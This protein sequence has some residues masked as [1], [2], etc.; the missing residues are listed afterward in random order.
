MSR[1]NGLEKPFDDD[2]GGHS[3]RLGV[4]VGDDPMP[5]DRRG[6]RGHVIAGHARAAIQDGWY[7]TGD[8]AKYDDDGFITI[9]D[10]LARFSKIG[11]EMV[12]HQKIEDEIH[13]ILGTSERVCVVT[14]VPD[15]RKGERLVVLHTAVN[16]MNPHALSH[17]LRD[18]GLPMLWIPSARDFV[19]IQE[20]PLLGSGK[21]DLKRARELA[22]EKVPGSSQ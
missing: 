12:P 15:E 13:Q 2:I 18:R 10:R 9:T 4:E 7:V 21:I 11:G 17:G 3:L 5:E 20:M 1:P 6:D 22:Q 14:S 16:G 8:L 19:Q